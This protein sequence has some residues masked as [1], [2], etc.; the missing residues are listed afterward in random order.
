MELGT[1]TSADQSRHS[2]VAGHLGH[3]LSFH[4]TQSEHLNIQMILS[5]TCEYGSGHHVVGCFAL[6]A[7]VDFQRL[8]NNLSMLV[9]ALDGHGCLRSGQFLEPLHGVAD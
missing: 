6:R 2:R 8:E 5:P 1:L 7:S 3:R 4:P 9:S